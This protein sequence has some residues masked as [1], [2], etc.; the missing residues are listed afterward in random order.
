MKKTV[1]KIFVGIFAILIL[2]LFIRPQKVV[3]E[4]KI[5]GIVM[6]ENGKPLKNATVSRI[7]KKRWKNKEFGYHES[8]DYKSQRAQ[9][10]EN[11][12]F[13]LDQKSRVDWFHNPLDLPFVW[14]YASFEVS[15]AGYETYKTKFSDYKSLRKENCYACENIE[16]KPQILLKKNSR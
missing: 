9:T 4:A 6:D 8:S 7:E 5:S 10:D 2:G 16:F 3:Y 14:C 1:I 13:Q 15:K 12:K 11:G